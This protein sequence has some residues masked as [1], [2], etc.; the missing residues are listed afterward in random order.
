[1]FGEGRL[2]ASGGADAE[3]VFGNGKERWSGEMG[4]FTL[5]WKKWG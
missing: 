1:M 3:L 5:G 2:Y 4:G